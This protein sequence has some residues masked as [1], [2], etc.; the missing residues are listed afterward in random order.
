MPVSPFAVSVGTVTVSRL[1]GCC[2]SSV[3]QCTQGTKHQA[4]P[5]G[6]EE[7]MSGPVTWE[8]IKEVVGHSHLA[9]KSSRERAHLKLV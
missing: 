8:D 7:Q 5:T 1:R 2:E 3:T 6:R 9:R 4:W